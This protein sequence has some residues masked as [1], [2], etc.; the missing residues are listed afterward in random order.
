MRTYSAPPLVRIALA[1][2]ILLTSALYLRS[3]GEAPINIDSIE[4]YRRTLL[5][6]RCRHAGAILSYPIRNSICGGLNSSLGIDDHGER[7]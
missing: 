7:I 5:F 1:V 3:L 4:R 6:Q 2:L